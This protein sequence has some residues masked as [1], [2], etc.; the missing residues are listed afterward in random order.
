MRDPS[1]G[2]H[3]LKSDF[4]DRAPPPCRQD[5]GRRTAAGISVV[6]YPETPRS[7]KERSSIMRMP[8]K[9]TVPGD[10][11]QQKDLPAGCCSQPA[12]RPLKRRARRIHHPAGIRIPRGL[13]PNRTRPASCPRKSPRKIAVPPVI[14]PSDQRQRGY[15]ALF[16]LVQDNDFNPAVLL[17]PGLRRI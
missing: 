7:R 4:Y 5:G 11:L 15:R 10:R 17:P 14:A 6:P 12:G 16:F 13:G 1:H 9:E 8:D 2:I 3:P